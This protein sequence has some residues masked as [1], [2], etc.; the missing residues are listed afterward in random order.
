MRYRYRAESEIPS[1]SSKYMTIGLIAIV[2]IA[3]A[4]YM[5]RKKTESSDPLNQTVKVNLAAAQIPMPP[6]QALLQ[7]I[8]SATPMPATVRMISGATAPPSALDGPM[9]LYALLT[10][11]LP[12][13]FR[14][15]LIPCYETSLTNP[16]M[17]LNVTK[18]I[19]KMMMVTVID[20]V[21]TV[22]ENPPPAPYP[23]LPTP[24][25]FFSAEEL[26]EFE[27][28][29]R[30]KDIQIS[31]FLVPILIQI[32]L[33]NGY[34]TVDEVLTY[35]PRSESTSTDYVIIKSPVLLEILNY[36]N[37][38]TEQVYPNNP[39]TSLS[40]N[41]KY[42]NSIM[43][44]MYPYYIILRMKDNNYTPFKCDKNI[45]PTLLEDVRRVVTVQ[46]IQEAKDKG[47]FFR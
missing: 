3:L 27:N 9:E 8:A 10:Y 21:I 28:K 14:T 41:E 46:S 30:E 22:R 32:M 1:N 36:C 12:A 16:R 13:A 43:D 29:I 2:I 37:S 33:E 5:Y 45:E 39:R 35:I 47:A 42:E 31:F 38:Q 11:N 26:T 34:K 15:K 40:L 25:G 44:I 7:D 17:A 23:G 24:K 4:I 18:N 6:S 20:S 19:I